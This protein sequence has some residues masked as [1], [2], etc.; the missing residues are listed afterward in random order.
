MR[1]VREENLQGG[2]DEGGLMR[3]P[4]GEVA[5]RVCRGGCAKCGA[6][7]GEGLRTEEEVCKEGFLRVYERVC[8][9]WSDEGGL[10]RVSEDLQGKS[11]EEGLIRR[12]C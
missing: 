5:R 12:V 8:R 7:G 3:S 6:S 10:R 4:R 9:G 1:S 11:E 2:S